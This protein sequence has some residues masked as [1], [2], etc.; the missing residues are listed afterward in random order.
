MSW[1]FVIHVWGSSSSA[2]SFV[3]TMLSCVGGGAHSRVVYIIH[4]WGLDVCGLWL[5][6]MCGV[7]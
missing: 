5:S 1:A 4:G 7:G 2:L 6:Y 3:G